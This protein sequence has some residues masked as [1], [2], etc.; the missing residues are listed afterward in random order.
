MTPTLQT[1]SATR[2]LEFG[3][4]GLLLGPFSHFWYRYLDKKFPKIRP[5]HIGI[6]VAL[7]VG[8]SI[9]YYPIYFTTLSIIRGEPIEKTMAELRKKL[10]LM[11]AFDCIFWTIFQTVNF[12]YIPTEFRVVGSKCSELICDTVLSYVV[13]NDITLEKIFDQFQKRS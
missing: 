9:F 1:Y 5:T 2:T 4:T 7:D 8:M 3:A 6:K 10:S 11:I 12:R 13:H